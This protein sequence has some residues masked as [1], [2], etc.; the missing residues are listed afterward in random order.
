ML[1]RPATYYWSFGGA[2]E[3][4]VGHYGYVVRALKVYAALK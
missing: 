3:D 4:F 1:L 2:D